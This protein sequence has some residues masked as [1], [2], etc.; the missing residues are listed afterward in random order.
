[1]FAGVKEKQ[2]VAIAMQRRYTT[3][4]N[5]SALYNKLEQMSG[6]SRLELR[7]SHDYD[8][9]ALVFQLGKYQITLVTY[10]CKISMILFLATVV[11]TK[12]DSDE[13]VVYNCYV[14]H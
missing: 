3:S 11:P 14:K 4:A 12:S 13:I 5:V 10:I 7:D 2:V 9:Y 6:I 8:A 1:M